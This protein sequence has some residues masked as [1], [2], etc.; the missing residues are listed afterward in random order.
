MK[1]VSKR[2]GK[3]H[4]II[5][6]TQV[7][8]GVNTDHLEWIGNYIAEKR[9]DVI[10]QLGDFADMP[11]LSSYDE[12][13]AEMEGR[14]VIQDIE[15][16][17]DAMKRLLVPVKHVKG[18][19]PRMV[20]TLGN[21]EDRITRYV[22][23]HPKLRGSL[24]V[25]NLGYQKVGWE[26]YPFLEIVEIDGIEYSHYFVSGAMGRPVS[27]AR[28]LLTARH[29]SAVMGHKQETDIAFHPK[30]GH[31]GIIAGCCYLHE[32]KYLGPQMQ[33]KAQRRQ[34]IML[35]EVHE[36]IADPMFVS[37]KFLKANYS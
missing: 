3:T 7:K 19:H 24:H 27:S 9:P 30:S 25:H 4:L 34:I 16:V 21:H 26:V 8:P 22:E 37:L 23:D 15:V 11:S 17:R 10:V 29:N 36:G 6:D 20:L 1:R 18:Y 35:H 5:P 28:A 14:L 32:E 13:K 12:G 33:G 2:V 31:F